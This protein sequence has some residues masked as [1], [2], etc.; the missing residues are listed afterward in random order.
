MKL[1][2]AL[3]AMPPKG[4][5]KPCNELG[6]IAKTDEFP[7]FY[8]VQCMLKVNGQKKVCWG[9]YRREEVEAEAD[10]RHVRTASSRD[11]MQEMFKGI[12]PHAL[13]ERQHPM[14]AK[15]LLE[16]AGAHLARQMRQ[17]T[18]VAAA[19]ENSAGGR[20]H[21]KTT[22][23]ASGGNS[24]EAGSVP[25]DSG[26]ASPQGLLRNSATETCRICYEDDM[27]DQSRQQSVA[28]SASA[29]AADLSLSAYR[30][31]FLKAMVD[32]NRH[33]QTGK[34]PNWGQWQFVAPA[35]QQ[36]DH[37]AFREWAAARS[38]SDSL[39]WFYGASGQAKLL[40]EH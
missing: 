37:K 1:S 10:L 32:W 12:F 35:G 14:A 31:K 36:I 2:V 29:S 38:R 17:K 33:G 22:V 34:K 28:S 27:V 23:A 24:A 3:R 25:G 20:A 39:S 15:R 7:P 21:Q 40:Q 19:E 11:A 9:P 4:A 6:C 30:R 5:E 13:R 26:Q 18:T 16:D 8:R